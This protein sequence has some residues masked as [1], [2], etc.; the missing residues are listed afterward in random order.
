MFLKLFGDFISSSK[1][2]IHFGQI[3]KPILCIAHNEC[4][5]AHLH[6]QH[7]SDKP[8]ATATDHGATHNFRIVKLRIVKERSPKLGPNVKKRQMS[9]LVA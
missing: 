8:T 9:L 6:R 3:E 7:S 5:H 1:Q 2:D 4:S